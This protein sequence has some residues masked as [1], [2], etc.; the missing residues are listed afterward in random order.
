MLLCWRCD[1]PQSLHPRQN[2]RARN[3]PIQPRFRPPPGRAR[4]V[5]VARAVAEQVH[6]S[7][8]VSLGN[9]VRLLEQPRLVIGANCPNKRLKTTF[10]QEPFNTKLTT[11]VG[12]NDTNDVLDFEIPPYYPD[13]GLFGLLVNVKARHAKP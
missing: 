3:T 12:F 13:E 5:F 2:V 7:S 11:F 10:P 6:H 4:H 8:R 1:R 9:S